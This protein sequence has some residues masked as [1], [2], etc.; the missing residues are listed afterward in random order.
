MTGEKTEKKGVTYMKIKDFKLVLKPERVHYKFE[1][2]FNG[3]ERLGK[4]MNDVLNENWK[5]VFDDVKLGY[6]EFI[7][8]IGK[9]VANSIFLKV[10]YDDLFPTK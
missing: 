2:L 6:E 9:H 3:D 7:G 10:P 8:S 5:E 1:N 4:Q